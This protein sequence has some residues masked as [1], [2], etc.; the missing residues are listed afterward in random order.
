[1]ADAPVAAPGNPLKL[2]MSGWL[3]LD[4][5]RPW[6]L[7]GQGVDDAVEL[8]GRV[9]LYLQEQGTLRIHGR[10]TLALYQEVLSADLTKL[11][12]DGS[13]ITAART[14]Y[15]LLGP[16][17]TQPP[18]GHHVRSIEHQ[19]RRARGGRGV[20]TGTPRRGHPYGP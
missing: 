10:P 19:Q 7:L 13:G 15:Y 3:P 11:L 1:M 20:R 16:A 5:W 4:E 17:R 9:D 14:G 6:D 18:G 8:D 2:V 12:H